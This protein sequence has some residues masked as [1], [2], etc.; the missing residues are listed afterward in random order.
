ML[1]YQQ[2]LGIWEQQ[3]SHDP[4]VAVRLHRKIVEAMTELRGSVTFA[5]YAS[6]WQRLKARSRVSRPA[7]R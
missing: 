4:L 6:Q 1:L 3:A 5:E 2:A 7:W